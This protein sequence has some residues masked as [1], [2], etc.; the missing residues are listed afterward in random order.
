MESLWFINSVRRLNGVVIRLFIIV[1]GLFFVKSL[2]NYVNMLIIV[3]SK[4]LSVNLD[5][6]FGRGFI[7]L[8]VFIYVYNNFF[9]N[10]I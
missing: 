9:M 2:F 1:N 5:F 4:I 6:F 10:F 3:F 8:N 7:F